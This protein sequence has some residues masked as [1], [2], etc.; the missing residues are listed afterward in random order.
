VAPAMIT[1]A[2]R[3][4]DAARR[5]LP[6][7]GVFGDERTRVRQV[8][9]RVDHQAAA[10]VDQPRVAGTEAAIRLEADVHVGCDPP[11][12]HRDLGTPAPPPR[13]T[14]RRLQGCGTR[15]AT[16]VSARVATKRKRSG[17]PE[18]WRATARSR[19]SGA[20]SAVT[21]STTSPA[22][23]GNNRRALE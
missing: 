8:P 11:E 23:C 2:M 6:H 4:D 5:R 10:A 1:V 17:C 18:T 19:R 3:V 22:P 20:S 7:R 13:A 21:P 15:M 12:P 16:D 14:R 9:E